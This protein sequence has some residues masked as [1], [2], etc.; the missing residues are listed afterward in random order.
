MRLQTSLV[1]LALLAAGCHASRGGHAVAGDLTVTHAVIPAPAS[2]S[3]PPAFLV[4]ANQSGER[5][6]FTGALTPAADSVLLHRLT[7]GLMEPATPLEIPAHGYLNFV[8][9]GYHLMLEGLRRQLAVG[10]TV[11]LALRFSSGV[12]L[13]VRVPVLNYTDAVSELPLR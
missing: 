4:I 12:T 7:G 6:T 11:T 3:E 10:D 13:S 5:V 2:P 1:L 8:P 9:G